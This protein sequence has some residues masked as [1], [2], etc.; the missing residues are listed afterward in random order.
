MNTVMAFLLVVFLCG[1]L[2]VLFGGLLHAIEW[3]VDRALRHQ[4]YLPPPVEDSR[5]SI[6]RFRRHVRG[7]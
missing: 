2:L 7:E 4:G 6:V 3:C 1:L 5:S